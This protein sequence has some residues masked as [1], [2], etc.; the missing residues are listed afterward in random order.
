MCSETRAPCAHASNPNAHGNTYVLTRAHLHTPT[1]TLLPPT[2]TWTELLQH[3]PLCRSLLMGAS[4]YSYFMACLLNSDF[5]FCPE[6]QAR[7]ALVHFSLDSL[8]LLSLN[9]NL[10]TYRGYTSMGY[11]SLLIFGLESTD[12]WRGLTAD[13]VIAFVVNKGIICM[14]GP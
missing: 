3:A 11:F 6:R 9:L 2:K 5:C 8:F 10:R 4:A 14:N 12:L 13:S 1:L 7:P